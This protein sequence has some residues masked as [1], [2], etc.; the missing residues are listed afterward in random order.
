[1]NKLQPLVMTV[2]TVLNPQIPVSIY[3]KLF[4]DDGKLD[5]TVEPEFI[6]TGLALKNTVESFYFDKIIVDSFMKFALYV[7]AIVVGYFTVAKPLHRYFS[8]KK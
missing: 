6:S 4:Y 8:R 7:S 5:W 1:M 2:L 3:G